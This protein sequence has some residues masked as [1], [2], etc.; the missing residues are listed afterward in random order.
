M[1]FQP[2][3][4]RAIHFPHPARAQRGHDFIGAKLCAWSERHNCPRLYSRETFARYL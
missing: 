3:V 2:R 1:A 4:A